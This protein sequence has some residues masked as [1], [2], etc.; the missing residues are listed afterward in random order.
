MMS[1]V[2]KRIIDCILLMKIPVSPP[3]PFVLEFPAISVF[4]FR[5]LS[6]VYPIHILSLKFPLTIPLSY[7]LSSIVV[8]LSS[9][10][11]S[12]LG[13]D[14]V[15]RKL[16]SNE[17]PLIIFQQLQKEGRNPLFMLR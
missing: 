3:H 11:F 17:K 6:S 2:G 16:S 15:E 4:H 14:I 9:P 12:I 7:P 8:L 13:P 5:F 10:S 1:R